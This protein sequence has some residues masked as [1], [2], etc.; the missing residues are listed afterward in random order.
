MILCPFLCD[1]V[2]S[3]CFRIAGIRTVPGLIELSFHTLQTLDNKITEFRNGG[4]TQDDLMKEINKKIS[5]EAA[6]DFLNRNYLFGNL[7]YLIGWHIILIVI[8]P[9]NNRLVVVDPNGGKISKQDFIDYMLHYYKYSL[10]S[11]R[12]DD[13]TKNFYTLLQALGLDL[14]SMK[15]FSN[16][17]AYNSEEGYENTCSFFVAWY[18]WWYMYHGN[19]AK[20]EFPPP[21]PDPYLPYFAEFVISSIVDDELIDYDSRETVKEQLEKRGKG[22]FRKR[23]RRNKRNMRKK[24]T[25]NDWRQYFY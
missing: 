15:F 2:P 6:F 16:E 10:S 13:E 4:C 9:H 18:L 11:L 23:N 12:G 3:D 17:D 8:E 7:D 25:F 1:M 24:K 19:S 22:E 20:D 21:Y 14:D 5:T